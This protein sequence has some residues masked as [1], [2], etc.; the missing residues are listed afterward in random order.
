MI[1]F[2]QLIETYN[3]RYVNDI[4][5]EKY[6]LDTTMIR[7]Y[8]PSEEINSSEWFEFG[9]YDFSET[10]YK[11]GICEKALSKEVMDSYVESIGYNPSIE[12]VV[13]IYLTKKKN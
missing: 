13:T 9:V 12:S 2:R 4:R 3:F 11:M 1:T 10:S 5:E 6:N 7:V 8:L